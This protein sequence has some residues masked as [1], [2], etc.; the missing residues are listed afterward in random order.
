MGAG[1]H[2]MESLQAALTQME[3][4]GFPLHSAVPQHHTWD[5]DG[6]PSGQ[7]GPYFLFHRTE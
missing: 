5:D 1:E 2:E 7:V 6:M 3:S 4:N